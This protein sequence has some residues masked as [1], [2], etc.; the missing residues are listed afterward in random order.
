M[1]LGW[2]AI[3]DFDG[4]QYSLEHQKWGRFA[5]MP[6]S[7][8]AIERFLSKGRMLALVLESDDLPAG[9]DVDGEVVALYGNRT[10]YRLFH[11]TSMI[12]T[13]KD[14]CGYGSLFCCYAASTD[15][16]LELLRRD[17]IDIVDKNAL[18]ILAENVEPDPDLIEE[19]NEYSYARDY[20]HKVS[21]IQIRIGKALA[22]FDPDERVER[23]F[24]SEEVFLI[25]D[26]DLLLMGAVSKPTLEIVRGAFDDTPGDY[27]TTSTVEDYGGH[28][29][30]D[31]EKLEMLSDF[32]HDGARRLKDVFWTEHSKTEYAGVVE[33]EDLLAA[34]YLK[35]APEAIAAGVPIDDVL[36]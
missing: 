11:W 6:S 5:P 10:S 15:P 20:Y 4:C 16:E 3:Y 30:C 29:A 31:R 33:A 36:S 22:G 28:R 14:R 18:K 24:M 1:L 21:M 12:A 27:R 32:W 2:T 13:A 8:E 26:V 9:D 17:E 19:L 25:D 34:L 23:R 35:H 7:A